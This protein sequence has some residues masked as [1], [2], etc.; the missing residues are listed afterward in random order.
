M[1]LADAFRDQAKACRTLG[2]PFMGRLLDLIAEH[3][4]T[5]TALARKCKTYEGDLGP[6]GH[7]LPLRICGGLHALRLQNRA[8]LAG[9][10]PPHTPTDSAFAE[11]IFAALADED[12]FLTDWINSPP[13]TNELRRSA[14]LIPGAMV[15]AAR[16]PLPV[17]LSE[18]GASGGLNMMWDRFALQGPGWRVGPA[19]AALT[20]TPDWTGPAPTGPRPIIA[21]RRG[22]DLGPLDP[23]DPDDLLRLTA[24]LW[25]DQPQR[26]ENTR[27]AAGAV[28][29][30]VD[31]GDAIDWL[32]QR[33]ADAPEG[34]MHLVQNTVAWQYFPKAA[35]D[36]GQA[37]MQAAGAEATE[38][39]PLAWL[40]LE[41]DGDRHG[42]G[43][44]AITLQLWP[45][46]TVLH[47]GRADFHGRWVRWSG[48]D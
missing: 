23:T 13:Q 16:F 36:R 42:H 12:A 2:S 29:A 27:K 37:L 38:T 31:R 6:A 48:P 40:Q 28:P 41:T 32:A 15:A 5:G 21:A 35:Q 10:Y 4:P 3:W 1:D 18:L 39:R 33:L 34:H 20:L 30:P 19:E 47:L 11:G 17:H 46:S 7:S 25:P 9:L 44:A 8:G 26:L 43:G 45:G 24:Y 22:V 14:A